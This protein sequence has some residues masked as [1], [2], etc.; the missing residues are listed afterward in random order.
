MTNTS[1][2]LIRAAVAGII[3][4]AAIGST[5]MAADDAHVKGHCMGA[6][7]CKGKGGCKQEANACKGQNACKGK[8][9][10]ETTKAKCDAMAKKNPE[11][12]FEVSKQ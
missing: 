9:Y 3:G 10:T 12:K 6:N 4:A 11:V 8:S 2:F 7:A 5:A 1:Q